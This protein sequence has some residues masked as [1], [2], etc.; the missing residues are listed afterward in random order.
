MRSLF[1]IGFNIY[2][3]NS[4]LNLINEKVKSRKYFVLISYVFIALIGGNQFLQKLE[5]VVNTSIKKGT[6]N[7]QC[8]SNR[9]FNLKGGS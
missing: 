3:L 7:G 1:S 2:L 8:L 6:K 5:K 9:I 4:L